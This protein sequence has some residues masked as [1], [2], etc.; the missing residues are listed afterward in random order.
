MGAGGGPGSSKSIISF[1][2]L[3]LGQLL[4]GGTWVVG[5]GVAFLDFSVYE[6]IQYHTGMFQLHKRRCFC[7]VGYCSEFS[8][9]LLSRPAAK[10]QCQ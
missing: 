4:F 3:V 9:F 7:V 5:V 2:E 10:T 1:L 8:M 6:S